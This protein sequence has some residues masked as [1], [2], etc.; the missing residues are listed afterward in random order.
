MRSAVLA[1]GFLL[2]SVGEAAAQEPPTVR[3]ATWVRTPIDRFVL[4][5]LEAQ[6]LVPAP[7][8]DRRTLLRRLSFDLVGLPPTPDE[9][10]AF[11]S[12]RAPDAYERQVDRLLASPRYGERWGRH[13]LDVVHYADTH[14]YDKDKRRPN[15]WPYRD[16]VIRALNEDIPYARFVREQL[17]GDL[18]DPPVIEA[19]GFLAAGPWDY[20]GHVELAEGTV[21]K[22]ITRTL[23]R[24]DM[25]A[26]VGAAFLSLTVQCA[27]CHDHKFDP[28]SQRD[29]YRMQAVFAG[30]DRAD[31]VV[32]PRTVYAGTTRFKP[33]GSFKPTQGKPRPIHILRRGDVR[34]PGEQVGP[35]AL[36]MVAA[37]P[38]EFALADPQSE[39]A[40]RA[41]LADWIVDPRND[42]TWRSIVNR[43]WHYHF[44]RGIVDTPNDMG[45]RGGN[46]SHPELLDWLAAR[47]R[48]NDSLKALHRLIVTSATYRQASAGGP[49]GEKLDA[50]NRLLWRMNRRRLDAEGLRDSILF[51]AG[52]LDLTMGGPGYDLF[53]FKDDHSPHYDYASFAARDHPETWRRTVYRFIVRSV[54]DPLMET[55]DCPDP[56]ISAPSRGA[57]NTA[58]QALALMNDRLVVRQSQALAERLAGESDPIGAAYLRILGRSPADEERRALTDYAARNGL[59]N[60]CRMLINTNEF[61]FVD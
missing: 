25:V 40:R 45:R 8:A 33:E 16:Y 21:D 28:I 47:F 42:L 57:T 60:A 30:I 44:G 22:E 61:V 14:G 59:A 11:E 32:E 35:G 41:A 13:W 58:L 37:L 54:P 29:Y 5:K 53:D 39:A 50:D 6:G 18:L 43:V 4:A 38:A 36:S 46:A 34:S 15:A 12:D 10:A 24:D 19:T 48:R 51:V 23:D 17:A 49:E 3:D 20:V 27:R 55:F 7:E 56:S 26:T 9:L 31:R 1:A 52:N 2:T